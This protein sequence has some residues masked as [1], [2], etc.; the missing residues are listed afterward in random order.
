MGCGSGDGYDLIMSVTTKD[1]GLYEYITAAVRPDMLHAYVGVDI[2]EDLLRQAKNYYGGLP[3][4]HFLSEDLSRGL[5]ERITSMAPFDLYFTSFGTLS[6]FNEEQSIRLLAGVCRHAKNGA[7]FMGDWLGR[8]SYEWQ[9]LWHKPLDREYFMNY[10][11]S[12]IYP[13]EERDRVD[14]ATFPLRL[15]CRDEI[16]RIVEK[17]AAHAG[18]RI[19]PIKFFDRSILV[20]RHL[21]TGDYNKNC[22]PLRHSINSLFEGY[23]RTDLENLRVDYVPREG[24]DHLNNFFESFFMSTNALVEYTIALLSGYDSEKNELRYVPEIRPFYPASLK[25]TMHSMRRIIEGVGWLP[26]GDV[27]ANVIEPHLGYSLRKL[28]MELQTG[29]GIGHSLVGIFEV[30][31][32]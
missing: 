17:A 12:Y 26:W 19:R 15:M 11:I 27:R 14:V 16:E 3:K 5:P 29:L 1:P 7:I 18:C 22:P 31:K 25:E 9:D 21:E 8:W 24:F 2:N 23:T 28:E 4:T 6:H 10:R 30:L 20:G 13:P 32:N